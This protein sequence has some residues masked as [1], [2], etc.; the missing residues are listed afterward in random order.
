MVLGVSTG[1]CVPERMIHPLGSPLHGR[2]SGK[3]LAHYQRA[4]LRTLLPRLAVDITTPIDSPAAL[5]KRPAMRYL[6]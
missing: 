1:G 2:R 3:P 5:F 6:A 4:L